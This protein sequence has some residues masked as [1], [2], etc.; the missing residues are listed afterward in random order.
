MR[1]STLLALVALLL[2]PTR[3]AAAPD[4]NLTVFIGDSITAF[5]PLRGRDFFKDPNRIARGV[6]RET[7]AMMRKRFAADVL[8]LKPGTVHIMGG[9]NDIGNGVDP[10]ETHAN[11]LA[12]AAAARAAGARVVLGSVLPCA[13]MYWRPG[14]EPAAAIVTL[15]RWL[16]RE[17]AARGYVYADYHT[18]LADPAGGLWRDYSKDGVHPLSSGYTIMAT[19]AEPL[20]AR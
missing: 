13:A 8:A 17:A 12:M 9:T 3:V 4:R 7:T 16:K 15:N 6:A 14:L 18:P 1:L 20:L 5:W 19:V 10:E 11:I 2:L